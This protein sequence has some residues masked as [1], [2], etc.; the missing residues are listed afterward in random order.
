MLR[1]DAAQHRTSAPNSEVDELCFL[2]RRIVV[3][4]VWCVVKPRAG[5]ATS[6][7]CP[8]LAGPIPISSRPLGSRQRLTKRVRGKNP[9]PNTVY[10]Q[11]CPWL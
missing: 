6:A 11:Q 7:L 5:L 8:G 1:G 9:I 2:E 4:G 10:Q 3:Q